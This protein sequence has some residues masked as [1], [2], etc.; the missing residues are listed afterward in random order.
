[1]SLTGAV[2]AGGASRRMGRDK[3]R[4]EIDGKTLLERNLDVLVPVCDE[5]LVVAREPERYA[6]LAGDRARL[7]ADRFD[8]GGALAGLHAAVE[9][10]AADACLVLAVDLPSVQPGLLSLIADRVG[11]ADALVPLVAGRFEPLCAL[12]HKACLAPMVRQ[13]ERGGDFTILRFYDEVRLLALSEAE[14]RAVDPDL[15][16]FVNVNRPEDLERL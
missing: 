7:V 12:Y 15:R 9:A 13:L 6:D 4:I 10:A 16:S 8:A 14:L 3:A 1:M 5:L 11:E 2:L